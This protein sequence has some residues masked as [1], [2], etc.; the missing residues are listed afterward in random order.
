M[1]AAQL[2]AQELAPE[3]LAMSRA[4][5]AIGETVAALSNCVCLESV[6]RAKVDKKGKVTEEERDA[7]QIEVTTIGDREWFSWPGSGDTFVKDPASL[8]GFGLMNTGQ[9]T[10]DLKTVFLGGLAPRHFRSAGAFQGRPGF[11]FD[12][13]ISSAFVHYTLRSLKGATPAGMR[14]SFW[15]DQASG[16]L[17]ALSTEASEIPPDFDM[18]SARTEVTYAPM[19]LEDLRVVMPQTAITRVAHADGNISIN[20]V[21]FSHC[22]PYSSTSSI[23]FEAPSAIA[24]APAP[25]AAPHAVPPIPAGLPLWLRLEQPITE[26]TAVGQCI[27]LI[28]EAEARSH[29]RPCRR[30]RREGAGTRT[31]DRT[32]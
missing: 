2:A 26:R 10:T 14:G 3:V 32:Y 20:R 31:P 19:Y 15:I 7:L 12:Y 8:V 16:D 17:L 4:T 11:E 9:L 24:Q 18:R 6:T 30:E 22:R 29:G 21:A 1:L 25:P 28:M 5:R 27:A 23:S 13:S